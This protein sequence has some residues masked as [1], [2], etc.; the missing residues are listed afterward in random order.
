MGFF[1]GSL[2]FVD[3]RSGFQAS[4]LSWKPKGLGQYVLGGN[5]RELCS[6]TVNSI[7]VHIVDV[8]VIFNPSLRFLPHLRP[9]SSREKRHTLSFYL[10]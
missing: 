7:L 10:Q 1:C 8:V 5:G 4:V 6:D 2:A 3:K 9:F